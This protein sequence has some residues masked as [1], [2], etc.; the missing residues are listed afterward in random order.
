M[1]FKNKYFKS[2]IKAT[3]I[4]LIL[5]ITCMNLGS[6]Q[7]N[8]AQFKLSLQAQYNKYENDPAVKLPTNFSNLDEMRYKKVR[9]LGKYLPQYQILLD[10]TE[11]GRC[12]PLYHILE[13]TDIKKISIG[14][15]V[16][17]VWRPREERIGSLNDILYFRTIRDK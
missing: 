7:L 14:M 8:K 9:V 16:Q 3:L 11:A 1:K 6:W 12:T 5:A 4:T 2:T 13:E 10:G 17:A 15:R